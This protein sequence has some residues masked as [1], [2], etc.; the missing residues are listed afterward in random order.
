MMIKDTRL[1]GVFVVETNRRKDSRGSFYRA[2]CDTELKPIL[3]GRRI[4]QINISQTTS[5]GAVRGLHFQYP[6]KA[7]MKLIRCLQGA[8]WDVVVDLRKGSNTFL[9]WESFLLD[10]HEAQMIVIPEGCGHGFQVVKENSQLLY[11]HTEVY[12]RESEGGVR[13]DEPL[14]GIEWP[15]PVTDI[16]ERDQGHAVLGEFEGI[17]I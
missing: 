7:E 6:P 9:Q 12:A 16:S 10:A 13:Y 8:V 4:N 3:S 11:L 2:F 15:L 14:L 1:D 5:V 17:V